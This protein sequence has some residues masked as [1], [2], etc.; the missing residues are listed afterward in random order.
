MVY[1][2][3]AQGPC[4]RILVLCA[5]VVGYLKACFVLCCILVDIQVGALF[6]SVTL[7]FRG[8]RLEIVMNIGQSLSIAQD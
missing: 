5:R 8:W 2:Y 4:K 6:K 1:M 7:R 3:V